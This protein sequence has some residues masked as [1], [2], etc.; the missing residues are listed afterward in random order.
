MSSNYMGFLRPPVV[1]VKDG[2]SRV[3][4]RRQ[5]LDD[6]LSTSLVP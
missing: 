3:V 5:R 6:L 1:F 2:E 4:E